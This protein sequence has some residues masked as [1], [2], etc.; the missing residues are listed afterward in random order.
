L[1]ISGAVDLSAQA[2]GRVA[3]DCSTSFAPAEAGQLARGTLDG[4]VQGRSL[5]GYRVALT[6]F[7]AGF[8]HATHAVLAV[9]NAVFVVQMDLHS[10]D[11]I[12]DPAQGLSI[13][14]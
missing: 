6:A 7:E 4:F 14:H 1:E 3:H 9:L 8:R 11:V 2:R 5:V 12:A 13:D 10:H